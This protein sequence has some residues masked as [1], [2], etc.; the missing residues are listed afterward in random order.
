MQFED[1]GAVRDIR[2]VK[3]ADNAKVIN[4]LSDVWKQIAHRGA[5]FA[6]LAELPRGPQQV[7]RAVK[8]DPALGKRE[9]L[10]VLSIE[11]R[12]GVEG[13]HMRRS[14][15]HEQKDH[16]LGARGKEWPPRLERTFARRF[17]LG[18]VRE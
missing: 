4:M 10:T 8:L 12:F 15:Q 6:V 7:A 5:T 2:P 11:A 3:R 9:R 13:V 17:G 18:I 16:P 1:R 14:A